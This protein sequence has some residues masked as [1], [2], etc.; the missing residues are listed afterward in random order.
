MGRDAEPGKRVATLRR[1]IRRV[2]VPHL[3]A[4]VAFSRSALGGLIGKPPLLIRRNRLEQGAHLN[5]ICAVGDLDEKT[6]CIS[7]PLPLGRDAGAPVRD[8]S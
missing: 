2:V 7:D 4:R 6:F 1:R 5:E 8:V 3:P